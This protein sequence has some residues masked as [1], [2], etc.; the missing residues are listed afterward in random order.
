MRGLIERRQPPIEH[1]EIIGYSAFA[2][3]ARRWAPRA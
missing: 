1:V 3:A 2:L